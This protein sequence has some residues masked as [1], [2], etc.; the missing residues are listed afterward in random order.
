MEISWIGLVMG[1]LLLAFPLYIIYTFDARRMGKFLTAAGWFVM[2]VVVCGLAMQA[3]MACNSVVI[4]IL[5]GVVLVI[6]GTILSLRYARL[7]VSRLIVPA[8]AGSLAASIAAAFYVLLGVLGVKIPLDARYFFPLIALATGCSVGI[9]AHALHIY[10]MGLR[11]H[12][13]LYYY[14]IGNGGTH[15]EAVG[16]FMKRCFQAALIP[17]MKQMSIIGLTTAPVVFF[18]MILGGTDV[19]TAVWFQIVL[20]LVT[21]NVSLLSLWITL[22]IGR[23][24]SFDQY[25]SLRPVGRVGKATAT[26]SRPSAT[27]NEASQSSAIS[28]SHAEP[29]QTDSESRQPES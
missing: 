19:W 22:Q 17:A 20:V 1:V 16:Y 10:Y 15:R 3:L 28:A 24:Y 25:E 12:R 11:H 13:Q 7:K 6:L 5:A 9:N 26:E 4:T 27:T 8:V 23:R 29:R 21:V 14:I 2:V 18:A